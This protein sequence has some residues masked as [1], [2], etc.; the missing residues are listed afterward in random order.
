MLVTQ[1]KWL[2]PSEQEECFS[3]PSVVALTVHTH[4]AQCKSLHVPVCMFRSARGW[5]WELQGIVVLSAKHISSL[6]EF[7]VGSFSAS[8]FCGP[9]T[10]V[11]PVPIWFFLVRISGNPP[12]C[13]RFHSQMSPDPAWHPS[14][15]TQ[16]KKKCIP[17]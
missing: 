7:G 2:I 5:I 11:N 6:Q 9:V 15:K 16:K 17:S 13:E 12:N 1:T 14:L 8:G 3:S 4:L 10:F